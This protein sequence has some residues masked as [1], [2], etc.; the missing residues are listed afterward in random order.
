M[1]LLIL[2]QS[3]DLD[4]PLLGFFHS[5]IDAL[6]PEYDS[7]EVVCLRKGRYALPDNVRV[8]SLGKEEGS[9]R[10]KY[11]WRF[12]T[13]IW[14]LRQE[15]DSVLVHMNQEYVLMG[16]LPWRLMGKR[17]YLW[18]NYHYGNILTRIAMY[19]AHGAFCTSLSS[20]TA[21]FRKTKLMPIGVNTD[22]FTDTQV[23]REKNAILSLGRIT[24]D[25]RLAVLVN[26]L[27]ELHRKNVSFKANVYGNPAEGGSYER[28]IRGLVEQYGLKNQITFN[29]GIPNHE[30]PQVYA[31]HEIFVNTSPSG[32][33]DKTLI[34]A[35]ASG[36]LVLTSIDDFRV[37][38]G[39]VF[40]FDGTAS[41]LASGIKAFLATPTG[42]KEVWRSQLQ[43][44]ARKHS[45]KALVERLTTEIQ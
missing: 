5:W 37:D 21:R 14:S 7:I 6:A 15:Y 42:Q 40:W 43:G 8:H 34:E 33:Y 39:E 38:A 11:V 3:V 26:A 18:R 45:L 20:Y 2:T 19:L 17:V 16:G 30:T 29:P 22:A 31:R 1:R 28:I 25:K 12:F 23:V 24:P 44:T 36:C 13:Y 9:S 32:M 41:G 35:A 4:E 27:Y 10:I